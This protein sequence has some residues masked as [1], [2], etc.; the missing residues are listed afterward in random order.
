MRPTH[1]SKLMSHNIHL[2]QLDIYKLGTQTKQTEEE[3]SKLQH[4]IWFSK[5]I[6]YNGY[7]HAFI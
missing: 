7:K 6:C 4:T 2:Y 5:L 3:Q 1:T